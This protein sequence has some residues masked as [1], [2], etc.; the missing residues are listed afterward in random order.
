MR[1]HEQA[2]A[3]FERV[4]RLDEGLHVAEKPL[5]ALLE[6]PQDHDEARHLPDEGLHAKLGGPQPVAQ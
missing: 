3:P 5:Q 6:A 1:L 4:H 2:H